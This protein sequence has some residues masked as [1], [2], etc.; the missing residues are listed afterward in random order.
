MNE[1]R[2]REALRDPALDDPAARARALA[3]VRVAY[4]K[5]EAAPRRWAP[6]IALAACVLAAAVVAVSV[7]APGDAVARWVQRVL[8]TSEPHARPALVR[9]PG[10]GRLLVSSGRSVWAVAP[11]GAR[12]RLGDFDGAS[13]SPHARFA[14]VWRDGELLAVEPG[15]RVH[16]SLARSGRIAAARWDAIDG[17]RI[18]YLSGTA[19]RI[20]NGDGTGDRRLGGARHVAPAWR[21]DDGHVVAYVD[22]G[23]HLRL[24]AVDGDRVLWRT[25]PHSR[26]F[27]LAWSPDGRRLV[28]ATPRRL[29][30]FGR[31]GQLLAV[32]RVA[33]RREATAVSFGPDG[34]LAVVRSGPRQA[35]VV[36]GGRVLFRGPGPLGAVAWSPTGR[37]LL[38]PWPE[39]DQWLF[40]DAD[41]GRVA[42]VGNIARQFGGGLD[43]RTFPAAVEWCCRR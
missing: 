17:F 14:V 4:G 29:L 15:G 32:R 5:R 20:V 7:T 10:G 3:V 9:V 21:P 35:D 11:D 8:G 16:W 38:V 39:A 43:A 31:G 28:A 34:R 23:R 40:L 18:A 41:G 25:R 27:Q 36:V 33:G 1:R 6:L 22:R 42:A 30:V 26:I 24:V 37:R 13:W 12:R 19:L 2:L